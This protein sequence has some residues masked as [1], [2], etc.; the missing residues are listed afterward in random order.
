MRENDDDLAVQDYSEEEYDNGFLRWMSVGVVVIA[1]AG[2]FA[3]A[4]YAYHAGAK[5]ESAESVTL[6][7]AD[8]S[9]LKETP[10]D[11]GGLQFPHQDK[12]VYD[13]ISNGGKSPKTAAERVLPAPEEPMILE[14]STARTGTGTYVNTQAG[15]DGEG[16]LQ[17]FEAD[18]APPAEKTGPKVIRIDPVTGETTATTTTV[19]SPAQTPSQQAPKNAAQPVEQVEV[20]AAP[21]ATKA[22]VAV[23]STKTA[24]ITAKGSGKVQL[25]A[26]KTDKEA[27]DSWEKV[28][29][30]NLSLVSGHSHNIQRAD[31]GAKGV[32]YRL[33]LGGFASAEEAKAFC[34]KLVKAAGCFPVKAN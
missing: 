10:A 7:E 30:A 18:D 31:L 8:K 14:D 25:G 21:V 15:A 4:W 24:N 3:L 13:A 34:N 19:L 32:F 6:V 22:K 2:F 23:E 16:A 29:K 26:F 17:V 33:Q 12:T 1:I 20:K 9:P 11:P 5:P 28:R 27:A